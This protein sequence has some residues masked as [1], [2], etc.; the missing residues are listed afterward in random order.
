[1]NS[2]YD[3]YE[4]EVSIVKL[5]WY[6]VK[7]W[8]SIIAIGIIGLILGCG[9]AFISVS[10]AETDEITI[11]DV[12]LEQS[13]SK[14]LYQFSE[15]RFNNVQEYIED[16]RLLEL[17]AYHLFK[18]STTLNI[19]APLQ[20]L[21]AI[22]G[23]VT[24]YALNGALFN[25]LEEETGL[26]NTKDLLYLVECTC[27]GAD[28]ITTGENQQG[29]MSA[30]VS[31][32][33]K[34]EKEAGIL[35]EQMNVSLISGIENVKD[36]YSIISVKAVNMSVVGATSTWLAEKQDLIRSKVSTERDALESSKSMLEDTEKVVPSDEN[37]I[38]K[39]SLIKYG[40]VGFV[41]GVVIG[42]VLW[43][44]VFFCSGKLFAVFDV[45]NRFMIKFLGSIH[46]LEKRN[47]I[48]RWISQ[49]G[50]GVYSSL[51]LE[52]QRKIALLNIKN[53]LKK[54]NNVQK[55]FLV[56]SQGAKISEAEMLK[57]ELKIAG[58]QVQGCDNV[59]GRSDV[60]AQMKPNDAVI[61]ME[62]EEKSKVD[63]VE[64]EISALK[65]YV[66]NVLGI[67]IVGNNK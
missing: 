15:E 61:V 42:F 39:K 4:E 40:G 62:N 19:T 67:V 27:Y 12:S 56:S 36:S 63:L 53:E 30:V 13:V 35:L 26:Y 25:E 31:V 47:V 64:A 46:N 55:V 11:E 14:E 52:E 29:Q 66:N 7:H 2:S 45:E 18:G 49:K 23:Y 44:L 5:F 57:E 54:I 6:C 33:A 65:E 43:I 34:T 21:E 8:K 24:S 38:S 58:Y 9:Y 16:S 59:I 60:L 32:L 17:D 48:D 50:K 41:G 1:M 10:G 51:S 3:K 37:D 22:E 28:A 20:N